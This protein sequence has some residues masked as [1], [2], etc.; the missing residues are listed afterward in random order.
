MYLM[1]LL[2]P[3]VLI[4][5][6]Q[7]FLADFQLENGEIVT[8]HCPNSGSMKGCA[9]PGSPAFISRCD[10]PGRKLCYT[11]ELVKADNC[12]IG[13]NTSLPNRLVHKAI[14]SGVI[15]ELQGYHSIRPEVRYGINSR[16]DLLLSRGDEL[17]YVEVKNVTLMEDG[18]AL[19]PD[20]ATVRGQKHLR[21]LM[22]MV[23]LGHRAV[24]FFVVQRPDCSS[25][26]P[27]DAIDPE[28]GRLLRLAAA[29]GVELLAYQ[30]HV[31]IESICI[32][33]RL[34]LLL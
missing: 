10:K 23:R 15:K 31:S 3:A 33:R 21:E 5:R 25:V 19:F 1:P 28:Y 13:I 9:V 27:A 17:C 7:R 22:E 24:N 4:R 8:A 34:A 11:W 26:S 32:E 29:S 18:R 30:A 6:Y 14:E 12:W 16:I 20:A 2:I